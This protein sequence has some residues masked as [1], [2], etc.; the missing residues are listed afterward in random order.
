MGVVE[1]VLPAVA[2]IDLAAIVVATHVVV[3]AAADA[4]L[5]ETARSIV[6]LSWCAVRSVCT[7][8]AGIVVAVPVVAVCFGCGNCRAVIVAAVIVVARFM[9]AAA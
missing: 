1:V 5:K 8:L 9:V 3:A 4:L 6:L 2:A 7:V